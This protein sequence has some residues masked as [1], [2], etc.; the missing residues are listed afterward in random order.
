MSELTLCGQGSLLASL[1]KSFNVRG[2]SDVLVIR[3][4]EVH[5]NVAVDRP[6]L[7]SSGIPFNPG[8]GNGGGNSR[9]VVLGFL[10]GGPALQ[11]N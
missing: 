7:L 1:V 6:H 5:G 11:R 2:A 3:P 10:T 4:F 8:A 9:A